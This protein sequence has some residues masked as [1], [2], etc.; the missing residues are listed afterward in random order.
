MLY[1]VRAHGAKGDGATNDAPAIQQAIDLCSAAG[2]GTVL[3]SD[4]TYL[5]GTIRLRSNVTFEIDASATLLASPDIADYAPD[6]HHN[7]YRNEQALDRCFIYAED[8]HDFS[9]VGRGRIDGNATAFPNEGSI[10]RP[11][12]IRLLRCHNVHLEGLRLYE[13]AAWT[14]AFLDSEY[15]WIRG[16]D[17]KN[18]KRYN[19]DGLDFDGCAH[20]FVSDCY[21]RGTDDNLCLQASSKDRPV[22]DVHVTN[23]AF[24]GVCAGLRFGLKSIGDIHDVT[25]SNCTLERVWR[26]GIKLESTEGGTISDISFSN[27]VMRDVT[28]PVFAI[29][30]NRFELDDYGTSVELDRMPEIGELK[31]ITITGLTATDS[32]EMA[33]VHRRFTDDVMGEP[34]FA[35][36]RF[37][38]ADGHPIEDVTLTDVRYTFIGGVKLADIPPLD[39]YPRLVDKLVEPDVRSSENYWPDWSRT[40]FMDLRNVRG[41]DMSRIRL[42]SIRPDERPAVL[43]DG[44]VT[45]AEPDVT[46]DGRRLPIAA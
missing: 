20:V 2:G 7:R 34:R 24:S 10:Y 13:S 46:V 3:L 29:L 25:V 6:V 11:M 23:C 30:N 45:V 37:D 39:E 5:A 32:G 44:C 19:G 43:T 14:T 15:I 36:F 40:A 18:D 22:H 1:D 27:I 31:R 42:K 4:G 28:R 41:L 38:A 21:V 12:M 33:N 16:V 9:I 8:Q 26:E 17:I 35:G